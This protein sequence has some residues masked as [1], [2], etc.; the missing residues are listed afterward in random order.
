MH[1]QFNQR[2]QEVASYKR[3][4]FMPEE[5]DLALNKAMFRLLEE[6]VDHKFQ[7]DQINLSHVTA[8]ISKNKIGEAIIPSPTD[9]VYEPGITSVYTVLPPDFYWLVNGRAEVVEDTVN[10]ETAPSLG[11]YSTI[12]EYVT[13]VAFPPLDTAPYYD[14]F[15][16]KVS[17]VTAYTSPS[18][19]NAGFNSAQ[20]KYVVIQNVIEYFYRSSG[21]GS[22]LKVYWERYRDIYYQDTFIFVSQNAYTGID[23]LSGNQTTSGTPILTSYNVYNRAAVTGTIQSSIKSVTN[24]DQGHLYDALT[25]N[26]FYNTRKTQPVVT[27]TQDYLILYPD[28]SFLITRSYYDYIRKPRTI[29]LALNQ[30]CELA[31]P[32]HP[33]IIDLALEIVRL[34]TKDQ[35]Y[36]ATVQDT[37]LRTT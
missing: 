14:N 10:C 17:G 19:I 31:D 15:R 24:K 11:A 8:L 28:K 33:R 4:K 22:A 5:I 6:G 23:L 18:A 27:Q 12:T 20:S 35:S 7:S 37:E 36:P 16:V 9:P 34:D 26:K 13:P 3:D 30:S 25:N 32:T 2:F 21:A 1:I 29:S